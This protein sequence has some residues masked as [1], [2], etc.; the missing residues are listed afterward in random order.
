MQLPVG[1]R[2]LTESEQARDQAIITKA[3]LYH[4]MTA[5]AEDRAAALRE[6]CV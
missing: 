3:P 5:A 1:A 4:Q 6:D 2:R